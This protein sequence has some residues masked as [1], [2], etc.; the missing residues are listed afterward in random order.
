MKF[1]RNF[2]AEEVATLDEVESY[3]NQPGMTVP[4]PTSERVARRARR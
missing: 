1:G 4:A 2:R 3:L